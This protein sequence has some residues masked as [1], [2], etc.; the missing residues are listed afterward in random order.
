M[1]R[2]FCG[3]AQVFQLG[4]EAKVADR[5]SNPQGA[6][7]LRSRAPQKVRRA[8]AAA[9]PPAWSDAAYR[10]ILESPV[11]QSARSNGRLCIW[12]TVDLGHAKTLKKASAESEPNACLFSIYYHHE[13]SGAP[14]K[15][16]ETDCC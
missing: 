9:V 16:A 11:L 4:R 14:P 6:L 7:K 8:S 2:C 10:G 3:E 15:P 13:S 1:A 5:R 12:E